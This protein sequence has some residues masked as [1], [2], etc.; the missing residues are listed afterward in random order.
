MSIQYSD[1]V[2]ASLKRSVELGVRME[3]YTLT[4]TVYHHMTAKEK[5]SF[6]LTRL[7]GRDSVKNRPQWDKF[8][9]LVGDGS[10]VMFSFWELEEFW[11]TDI[12]ETYHTNNRRRLLEIS[13]IVRLFIPGK[14]FRNLTELLEFL[15][16]YVPA[17][18]SFTDDPAAIVLR[19][20]STFVASLELKSK[21]DV[22]M[23]L[24]ME[25]PAVTEW[26]G[27][28]SRV[29]VRRTDEIYRLP[30]NIRTG[31]RDAGGQSIDFSDKSVVSIFSQEGRAAEIIPG[32]ERRPEQVKFARQFLRALSSDECFLAE[33]G[34][35]TGKSL[36]YLIPSLLYSLQHLAGV[37]VST[38]TRNLQ[39]QLY[40]KDLV[41]AEKLTNTSFSSLLLK[42]RSNYL[43]LLKMHIARANASRLFD[44]RQLL[45]MASVLIW[46][47]L[48]QSGDLSELGG[49]SREVKRGVDC[50]A[51][52]CPGPM[53]AH[54][55]DCF[56]FRA[57]KAAAKSDVIVTNHALFFSDLLSES[58][59][60]GKPSV[61]VF[62]E[63]H[64]IERVATDSLT[65]ELS[66]STLSSIFD[67]LES[68]DPAMP[69]R[70]QT[71]TGMIVRATDDETAVKTAQKAGSDC[72]ALIAEAHS[73][74][75]SLFITIDKYVADYRLIPSGYS[76]R[77]R[78]VAQHPLLD[79]IIPI[80]SE[81]HDVFR[82]LEQT[83]TRLLQQLDPSELETDEVVEAESIQNVI[84]SVRGFCAHID[85]LRER[86]DDKWVRWLEVTP[87]GWCSVKI[88]PVEI[89]E[90]LNKLV[91][92]K[93]QRLLLTSATMTVERS[94][95]YI[96]ERLGLD[97]IPS[98]AKRTAVFGSSYDFRSQVR[99]VCSAYLPSPR[100][101]YY[102][103]K[104]SGFLRTLFRKVETNTLVLFTSYQT[105]QQTVRDLA[106]QFPKLLVQ[107]GADSADKALHDFVQLRPAIL[108]GTESFWQ[109]VDLP[110][111]LLEVLVITRLPFSVPGDPIDS[112]RMELVEKKGA[113]SFVSYSL[114]SA[115]LRF[116]QGFGR[117]IRSST[118]QGVIIVT[119]N[120]L[121]K[122]S[123]GQ[124]FLNSVPSEIEIAS[125]WE[126]VEN[127][128]DFLQGT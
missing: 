5:R 120:R 35:G 105:L 65:G 63:A 39:N 92:E 62:D 47:D 30:D 97:R 102:Q 9:E 33:A 82:N 101:D 31:D 89:G 15:S 56:F 10:L 61:I 17:G 84:A 86:E 66:R 11:P 7:T 34:T 117:L 22:A 77:D 122:S 25:M 112:A 60:L 109:G 88:A 127:A 79:K 45:E 21:Q 36:A 113:N 98:E 20:L 49:L 70:L 69:D 3:V 96:E 76:R 121:V 99:F 24:S 50:D 118:D 2:T 4:C 44:S 52:F 93:Y 119:D 13:E 104:L 107:E 78:L 90:M 108:F 41:Q 16:I 12:L 32:Y 128:V 43:C 46:K 75:N 58:E 85:N 125:S 68:R 38:H 51:G 106:G 71:V 110:G 53:C 83:M 81:L 42:G 27:K 64:Q 114:P 100:S 123:F 6:T 37:V 29:A 103:K 126:E 67:P 59:I 40:Y 28:L 124:V 87:S 8:T 55:R 54:Y 91:Y 74:I 80:L 95:E 23:L 72:S 111:K 14:T 73:A 26:L 18:D 57:R 94:F 19:D 116:K 48:S 115:V 1:L